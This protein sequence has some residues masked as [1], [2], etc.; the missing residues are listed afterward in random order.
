M[1]VSAGLPTCMEGMMYPVPFASPSDIVRIAKRAEALGYH[2]VWGNDHMT[3][4]RY[5][6]AR[7]P[8][9]AQLLGTVNHLCQPG[10]SNHH[11]TLRHGHAG[12]AHPARYC[13]RRKAGSHT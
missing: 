10:R 9:A 5:V 1:I 11:I 6:R 8:A 7:I 13:G 12:H 2:S 4:Q 3:T